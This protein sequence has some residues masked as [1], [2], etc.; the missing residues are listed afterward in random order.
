MR[1]GIFISGLGEASTDVS[2]KNYASRWKNETDLCADVPLTYFLTEE[3]L[4]Y[5]KDCYTNK[6]TVYSNDNGTEK[7]E[8]TFYSFNYTDRLI[9]EYNQKS[10]LFKSIMLITTVF[11]KFPVLFKRLFKSGGN[12]YKS[13]RLR[14]LSFYTF[15]IFF[16]LALGGLLLL[17]GIVA[18]I[19]KVFFNETDSESLSKLI[20]KAPEWIA[21]ALAWLKSASL[22]IA[23]IGTFIFT[24]APSYKT[25]VARLAAEFTCVH[26]YLEYGRCKQVILGQLDKLTEF[27]LESEIAGLKPDE[28]LKL[29]FHSYSFGSIVALDLLFPYVNNTSCHIRKYC[30]SL[31]TIGCPYEFIASYYPL[32]FSERNSKLNDIRWINVYSLSDAL[33]SNFRNDG[34]EKEPEFSIS[35][36]IIK[37]NNIRYELTSANLSSPIN[38]LMLY[39]I[40]AH[41]FYWDNG[42]EGQ[43]CIR[44]IF[45]YLNNN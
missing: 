8:Y 24:F 4:E 39:Q 25:I 18:L 13:K 15:G 14:L 43:S 28:E 20:K 37:P 22:G 33:S 34:S 10:V 32:Y 5:I 9:A 6:V 1:V 23:A 40:K 29:D 31:I 38:F 11:S 16:I 3:R 7:A 42:P 30:K 44:D 36:N 19:D 27:V 12:G 41:R 21:I 35:E 26:H 45:S 17:P 2:V